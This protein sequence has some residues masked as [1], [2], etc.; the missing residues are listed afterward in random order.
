MNSTKMAIFDSAIRVFSIRGYAGATMDEIASNAGVA[1]GTLYYHFKSKEDIFKFIIVEGLKAIIEKLNKE[2]EGE[3]NPI[4]KIKMLCKVQMELVHNYKDLFK[5]I[6][7]QLWGQEYRQLEL[8]KL[9]KEY[10]E[11]LEKY[12]VEGMTNGVIRK[13]DANFMAYSLFGSICSAVVFEM[14]GNESNL[15][16]FTKSHIDFILSGLQS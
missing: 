6:M 12:L 11:N 13:G 7:S 2:T 5:V 3:V 10:I 8:R 9:I 15:E 1:K 14:I 16:E 4:D